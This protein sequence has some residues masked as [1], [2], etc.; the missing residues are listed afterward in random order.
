MTLA[1]VLLA[2]VAALVTVCGCGANERPTSQQQPSADDV[3]LAPARD[4]NPDPGVFELNLEAAAATKVY[5]GSP[6]TT[7]WAYNGTVPGP[8]IDAKV[9]DTLI[10]H[11]RNNLPEPTTIHW[12]GI[13]LP[14]AMDGTLAMQKPVPPGGSFEYR[15]TL[16]DAGLYWYHPHIRSD[17]QVQKGL[18]GVIRV[19]GA[20][21]PSSDDEKVLVLDDVRLKPDGSLAEF[22]DDEAKMLGREGNTILVNG[23]ALATLRLRP[24]ALVRLRIVNV[25]NGRFFN[26]RIPGINSMRV[27]GTDGGLLPAPYDVARLLISPG[28]RYDVMFVAP[29]AGPLDLMSDPYERGHETGMKPSVKVASLLVEGAAVGSARAL[30]SRFAELQRL[31][32]TDPTP[33]QLD[34]NEKFDAKGELFFTIN[35]AVF[36]DVPMIMTKSGNVRVFDVRNV[37]EMDHPF[38]LHGFFFQVVSRSGVAEPAESLAQKDTIIVPMKST[39]RLVSRLDEPGGW[40]YHCHILEHAEGGMMGEIV[41]Q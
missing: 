28:E 20:D 24:G 27:I 12:H 5:G 22:L 32:A 14:A 30:P 39:L 35:D 1:Q 13:R 29:S 7:V 11:F 38:H 8:F 2:S 15:Y 17:I 10:I 16:K 23:A 3:A 25:A 36:P 31:P 37:S 4:I 19:R 9:G 33:I 41:V 34:L 26:L 18:Y 40:M 21:E 6:A